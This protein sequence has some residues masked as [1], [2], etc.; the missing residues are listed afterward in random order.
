MT[1][2]APTQAMKPTFNIGSNIGHWR[3]AG[4]LADMLTSEYLKKRDHEKKAVRMFFVYINS[5]DRAPLNA[6]HLVI[7]AIHHKNGTSYRV[8]AGE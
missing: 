4:R 3:Y 5:D 7:E 1:N 2:N 6:H 8:H